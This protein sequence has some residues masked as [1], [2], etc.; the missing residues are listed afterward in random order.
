MSMFMWRIR[1]TFKAQ[2]IAPLQMAYLGLNTVN[3][4]SYAVR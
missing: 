2:S 1:I 4:C 3:P